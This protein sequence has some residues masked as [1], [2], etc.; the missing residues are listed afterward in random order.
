MEC[1]DAGWR[2]GRDSIK[3]WCALLGIVWL[4]GRKARKKKKGKS[5]AATGIRHYL[6]AG[7]WHDPVHRAPSG[8]QSGPCAHPAGRASRIRARL[9]RPTVSHTAGR[10]VVGWRDPCGF[11][12][13]WRTQHTRQKRRARMTGRRDPKEPRPRWEAA[14]QQLGS[15]TA[16]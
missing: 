2:T 6:N 9:A 7:A 11:Q 13:A 1:L 14:P 15:K 12:D 3:W 16:W 4:C 10:R 5:Q 8:G